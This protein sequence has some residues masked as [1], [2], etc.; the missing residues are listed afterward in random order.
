[1][2]GGRRSRE[3]RRKTSRLPFQQRL[4]PCARAP[5]LGPHLPTRVSCAQPGSSATPNPPLGSHPGLDGGGRAAGGGA[6]R[7]GVQR[8]MTQ[9]LAAWGGGAATRLSDENLGPV[10]PPLPPPQPGRAECVRILS[11]LPGVW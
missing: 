3:E 11:D 5:N 7:D 2:G 8:E 6:R 9:G 4:H 10:S 1:M